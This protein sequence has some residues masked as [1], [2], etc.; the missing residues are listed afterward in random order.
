MGDAG[1]T[2]ARYDCPEDYTQEKIVTPKW[3]CFEWCLYI[4]TCTGT[5]ESDLVVGSSRSQGASHKGASHVK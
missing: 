5:S 3:N 1:E 4:A 2:R